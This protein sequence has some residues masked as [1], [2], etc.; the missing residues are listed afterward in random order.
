[1]I[2]TVLALPTDYGVLCLCFALLGRQTLF[3]PVYTGMFSVNLAVS[4]IA[5][6]R[7]WRQVRAGRR[8]CRLTNWLLTTSTISRR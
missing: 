8:R 2:Q 6:I 4:L 7:W 3:R 1:M 5:M